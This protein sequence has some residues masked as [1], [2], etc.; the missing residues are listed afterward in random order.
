MVEMCR[1]YL[2]ASGWPEADVQVGAVDDLSPD[3]RFDVAVALDVIEHIADDVAALQCMRAAVRPGGRIIVSVPA[4]SRLYGPK[5]VAI[6]HYRRYD[7]KELVKVVEAAGLCVERI[8]WWNAIGLVPVWLS[9]R[10]LRRR[11]NEDFR[12]A[13]RSRSKRALNRLLA[14]WFR[15][16][17]NR[18][19]PPLGLTL[20]VEARRPLDSVISS[21]ASRS[22]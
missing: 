13:D 21:S 3:G 22:A 20:L 8:R 19:S 9:V 4:I 15:S 17:E 11:L 12:Y 10:L 1:Q 14:T 18:M 6:G 7:R 2:A 16:V 5:D